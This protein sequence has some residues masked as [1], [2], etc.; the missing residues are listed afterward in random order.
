VVSDVR[1]GEAVQVLERLVA[2]ESISARPNLDLVGY[3]REYLAA[4]GVTAHLS[5]DDAR[6]R[7]NLHATIGPAVDGGVVL[8]G[9]TDVVPVE[10]QVWTSDPFTLTER[11]GRLHGRGAVDMKGFLACMLASVPAWQARPLKRPIHVS[12]CYDEEIGGFGAPVLVED[13]G[14]TAPRPSVAIVGEPTGM[15][16]VSGHKG[17][18]EMRTMITGF[19]AHASDPRKGANAIVS[20]ARFIA[21][22]D[23]LGRELAAAP[24]V[25]SPF[26][27]AWTTISVGT[28]HGGAA[29][30]IIAGSCVFDW[31]L[32]PVP[33]DDGTALIARI[34]DYARTVL[35]PE[36]RAASPAAD[37]RTVTEACVPPLNHED[38]REAVALLCELTGQN[39]A[40]VVS[41]GTDAGHFCNAGISTV[42]FGPGSIDQAHKPD[43]YIERSQ[44]DACMSFLDRLGDRLAH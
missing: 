2:F 37:I 8:N 16:I 23:D 27:P 6:A 5:Y 17:G 12:M 15:R 36:M 7:A 34:D 41:F 18:F 24:R 20:A 4:R 21:M 14:R 13:M 30:N 11:D 39:S 3:V 9:H 29:R 28:I 10:G 40:D 42:V 35:L 25:G 26:D 33:G 19:E 32:R 31:E 44:I 38:A 43:E 1:T 22:L